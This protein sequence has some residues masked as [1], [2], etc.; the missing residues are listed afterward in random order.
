MGWYGMPQWG[1]TLT[2]EHTHFSQD[3]TM[4]DFGPGVT[5]ES[6]TINSPTSALQ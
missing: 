1:A 3:T 5:I 2:S 4:A 6:L